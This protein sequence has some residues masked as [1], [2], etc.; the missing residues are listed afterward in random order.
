V[1]CR[2][3]VGLFCLLFPILA[4]VLFQDRTPNFVSANK[5]KM[6]TP[7]HTSN[8]LYR[9]RHEKDAAN[10]GSSAFPGYKPEL[11]LGFW[12]N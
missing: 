10:I 7:R 6:K 12:E 2:Y 9:H 8:S 1:P 3:A 4:Q 5:G 11:C